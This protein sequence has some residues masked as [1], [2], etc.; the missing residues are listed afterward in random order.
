MKVNELIEM[1]NKNSRID[2]EKHLEVKKYI[3]IAYKKEL[4][5]LVLDNCTSIVDDEIHIDSVE[6]YMLFTVAV[7]GMHTN[8]EFSYEDDSE[9]STIDDYDA[10]CESG[11]LIKIIDTF[12]DDY[13]ACQEVLNMVT[14]DRLQTN[15]TIEKKIYKFVDAIETT[16]S[17]AINNVTDKLNLDALNV[18]QD[19]LMQFFD[20][21]KKK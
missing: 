8:L 11:L 1:Y 12:K 4:A 21:V 20:I 10:L 15:M 17:G 13:L 9:F 7:I 14:S 2:L 6:K 19:T 16:L 5:E 18:N 3:G